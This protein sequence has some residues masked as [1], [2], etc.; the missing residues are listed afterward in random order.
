MTNSLRGFPGNNLETDEANEQIQYAQDF[1]NQLTDSFGWLIDS[2]KPELDKVIAP[3]LSF[4]RFWHKMSGEVLS[5]I[6]Y[7][8]SEWPEMLTAAE[9]QVGV[10]SNQ[11]DAQLKWV[12]GVEDFMGEKAVLSSLQL[13]VPGEDRFE[14]VLGRSGLHENTLVGYEESLRDDV[15]T[16]LSEIISRLGIVDTSDVS[17]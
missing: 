2:F 7:Q 3:P 5:V 15:F 8:S 14:R 11:P 12:V 16:G 10:N 13:K 4:G 17:L 9:F 6:K 1:L